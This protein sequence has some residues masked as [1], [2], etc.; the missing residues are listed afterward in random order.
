MNFGSK[1]HIES[2]EKLISSK[3]AQRDQRSSRN[4]ETKSKILKFFGD[5]MQELNSATNQASFE[6]ESG[7]TKAKRRS[8]KKLE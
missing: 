7:K 4:L 1:A 6:S 5:V 2:F 3:K 8:D